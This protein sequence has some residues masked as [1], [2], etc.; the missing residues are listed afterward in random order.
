M[1]PLTPGTASASSTPRAAR[2]VPRAGIGIIITPAASGS[3]SPER[4]SAPVAWRR[5][6]S[7]SDIPL[8]GSPVPKNSA[9]EHSPPID[10]AATSTG[11]TPS[12]LTRSSACSGPSR[13][14]SAAAARRVV[15]AIS[16]CSGGGSREGV[17]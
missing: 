3:R 10:R 4:S 7:S 1:T 12:S 5:I 13:S 8:S 9:R 17:M 15:S 2:S 11:H 14:P 16:S 6:S